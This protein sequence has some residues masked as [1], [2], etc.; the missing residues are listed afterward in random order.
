MQND[1]PTIPVGSVWA[2]PDAARELG[3]DFAAMLAEAGVDASVFSDRDNRISCV[4]LERLFLACERQSGC[5]WLGT[6]VGHRT[7]LAP[8]G[9]GTRAATCANTAGEGL[10][11]LIEHVN[12]HDE[13]AMAHLIDDGAAARFAYQIA[14]HGLADTRHFEFIGMAIANH[15][16]LELLGQDW[17]PVVVRFAGPRPARVADLEAIFRAPLEFGSD[18][19]GIVFER[20]WLERALPVVDAALRNAVAQAVQRQRAATLANLP[21]V[22]RR[23]LRKRLFVGDF[24][25]DDVAAQLS[26]HRRTL[27]RHLQRHGLSYSEVL[28]GVR[29]EIARQLLRETGF[30]VQRVAESVRFSSAANFATAFRRRAGMTPTE[31]RRKA[32]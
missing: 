24:S 26:M 22:L 4:Q 17:R 28:E 3:L 14:E 6:L 27:D 16:L 7:G 2:L 18:A 23:I 1:T 30:S 5:D 31:F 8:I 19:A 21:A 29:D 13:T 20:R 15:I 25:M 9:F 32:S 11:I 12:L 10:R